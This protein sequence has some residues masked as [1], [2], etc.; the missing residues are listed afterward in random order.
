MVDAAKVFSRGRALVERHNWSGRMVSSVRSGGAR[1][2][3]E[4]PDERV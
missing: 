1:V 2:P 4:P 3:G